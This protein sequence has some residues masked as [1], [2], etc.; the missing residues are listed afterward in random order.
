MGETRGKVSLWLGRVGGA[1]VIERTL[2][3]KF[4]EDGDFL[5]CE[6]SRAFD[7]GYYDAGVIESDYR[8]G[9]SSLMELLEGFSYYDHIVGPFETLAG[10]LDPDT[11]WVVLLFDYD[12][13]GPKEARG[14]G[15]TMR[16]FGTISYEPCDA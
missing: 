14:D 3:V 13:E 1:E 8:P 10:P 2:H 7:I 11:N 16:Y 12:H 15:W 5:G 9:K 6:F 4:S